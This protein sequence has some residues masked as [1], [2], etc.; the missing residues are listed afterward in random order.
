ML[1]ACETL[2]KMQSYRTVSINLSRIYQDFFLNFAGDQACNMYAT[3]Y[4]SDYDLS[5]IRVIRYSPRLKAF[6][7]I[8]QDATRVIKPKRLKIEEMFLSFLLPQK[9]KKSDSSIDNKS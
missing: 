6:K 4:A 3:V 7:K 9:K 1:K 8:S 2:N 5:A